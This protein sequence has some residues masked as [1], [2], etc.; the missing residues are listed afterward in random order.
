VDLCG[1]R[2]GGFTKTAQQESQPR[3]EQI[4]LDE[5]GTRSSTSR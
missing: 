5:I 1:Y 3:Y 4:D 2:G